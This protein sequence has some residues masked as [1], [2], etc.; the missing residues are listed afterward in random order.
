MVELVEDAKAKGGRVLSGGVKP[1]GP[2]YFYPITFV[3]DVDH[4]V[5]ARRRGAVRPGAADHPLSRPRHHH[6]QG[7]TTTRMGSAVRVWSSDVQKARELAQKLECGSAWVNKHGAIQPNAPFGGV[8]SFG[9]RG[10]VSAP[11][12]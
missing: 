12:G 8:K 5:R 6:R 9:H 4:G 10:R 2:G 11:K 7:P 3:A 1:N